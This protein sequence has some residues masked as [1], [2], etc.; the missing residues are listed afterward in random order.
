MM[1]RYVVMGV[2]GCGKSEIGVVFV[3][4]IGVCFFDGDDFY[5][6][7]NIVK[8]FCGELFND[9]DWVLWFDEIGV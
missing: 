5:L 2:L 1:V 6:M 9:D 7:E 4:V 8:M 3:K